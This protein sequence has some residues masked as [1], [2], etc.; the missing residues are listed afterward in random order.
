MQQK[1]GSFSA[2]RR[3]V[4]HIRRR[5]TW[6][7]L[8]AENY[9]SAGIQGSIREVAWSY[10]NGFFLESTRL[11]GLSDTN[12]SD[13]LSDRDFHFMHPVNQEYSS[14]IDNKLY[15]PYLF[16]N[17][18]ELVPEYYYLLERGH[19]LRLDSMVRED[20]DGLLELLKAKRRLVLKPCGSSLGLGFCLMEYS[21]GRYSMNKKTM[22]KD[23]LVRYVGGLDRYIVTE[24]VAQHE[25][26][27][28]IHALSANTV[29]M[30]YIRG[31]DSTNAVLARAFHRFGLG[32]RLVDNLGSGGGILSYI[33][34]RDGAILPSGLIKEKGKAVRRIA[35]DRHPDT[36][37]RI[38]GVKI[39][40]W[41]ELTTTISAALDEI[42]FL[43]LVALDVVVTETG[44]KILETNSYPT[45]S[46]LQ[47][48]L[49]ICKDKILGPF[50][51][52]IAQYK[53]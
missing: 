53:V 47:A 5:K 20:G 30:L 38:A 15:L 42:R 9:R 51:K 2:V 39:P 22:E 16:K 13:Y 36:N 49:P 1:F 46:A 28:R 14:I 31:K 32:D 33:D 24:Y 17:R 18:P 8:F 29:R 52:G 10:R 37:E 41:E 4:Q 27:A 50:F 25:Y 12:R 11:C 6:L 43:R 21:D 45:I 44:C 19:L 35:V 48:E 40:R 34:V 3:Y 7:G 26:S 23:E